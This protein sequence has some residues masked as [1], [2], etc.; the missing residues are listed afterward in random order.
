MRD[1]NAEANQDDAAHIQGFVV[2]LNKEL[3]EFRS[4]YIPSGVAYRTRDQLDRIERLARAINGRAEMIK[5]RAER[6]IELVK[7]RVP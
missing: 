2:E 7:D 5:Q 1:T 3:H 4:F 6:W